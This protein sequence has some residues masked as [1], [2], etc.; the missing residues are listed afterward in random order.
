MPAP[1]DIILAIETSNP[2]A[3]GPGA[4]P[5]VALAT[6]RGRDIEPLLRDPKASRFGGHDDDLMPAIDRLFKRTGTSPREVTAVAVSIGPG[7]YTGL[8]VAC[9][10]A[11]MIAEAAG[12]KCIAVPTAFALARR[13][14]PPLF[15][16]GLVAISV[17][18]KGES[19]WMQVFD[20]PTAA[21]GV[22]RLITAADIPALAAAGVRTIVT[23]K[24]L[25]TPTREAAA[26]RGVLF[27]EP[28]YDA[29]AVLE[30]AAS[31]PRIDP[32]ELV[33]LYPRE[34]DAVTLWR[35]KHP[36]P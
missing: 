10:V 29:L 2:S 15:S 16:A 17:A 5:S 21:P 36:K 28:V 1:P 27:A 13:V 19:S 8:R 11:K 24:F 4:G 7:G 6:P 30:S 12:A 25:P 18:G 20:S 23:D 32:V 14:D 31:L 34:P 9:A 26:A 3:D 33:P 35:L 22:G